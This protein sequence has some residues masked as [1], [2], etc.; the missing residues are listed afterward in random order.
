MFGIGSFEALTALIFKF[1]LE[2]FAAGIFIYVATIEMLSVEIPHEP[3][4]SGFI[5]GLFVILG[6][7]IFFFINLLL[8]G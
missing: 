2:G 3:K 4:K 8:S 6:S 5:K 7:T 1:I